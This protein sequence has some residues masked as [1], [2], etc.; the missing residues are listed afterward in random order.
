MLGLISGTLKIRAVRF[1]V[2]MYMVLMALML[3]IIVSVWSCS[4]CTIR[5][6]HISRKRLGFIFGMLENRLC[7]KPRHAYKTEELCG[8]AFSGYWT[9]HIWV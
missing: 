5:S 4:N 7:V 2:Y 9:C 6:P 1:C 8:G 3:N